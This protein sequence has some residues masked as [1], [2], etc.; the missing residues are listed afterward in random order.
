MKAIVTIRFQK[1]YWKFTSTQFLLDEQSLFLIKI[2]SCFISCHY[3]VISGC[4][5]TYCSIPWCVNWKTEEQRLS[6]RYIKIW[7]MKKKVD[8]FWKSDNLKIQELPPTLRLISLRFLG[9]PVSEL[10]FDL[11]EF[12]RLSSPVTASSFSFISLVS[13]NFPEQIMTRVWIPYK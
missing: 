10:T 2:S 5:L 3:N 4:C 7:L 8:K 13:F 1:L 9:S 12:F 6:I 11:T